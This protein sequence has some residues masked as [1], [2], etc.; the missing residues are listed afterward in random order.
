MI[1][2]V[3][4]LQKVLYQGEAREVNCKT[5]MGEITILDHHRPLISILRAGTM[6]IVDK[7]G[8]ESYIPVSSGFIEVR[9]GNETRCL[10]EEAA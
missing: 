8:Q 9:N 2:G 10:I 6:K 3:Y 5:A 1:V 4:S 7:N